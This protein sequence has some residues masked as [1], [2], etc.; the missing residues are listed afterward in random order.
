MRHFPPDVILVV[1]DNVNFIVNKEIKPNLSLPRE[2]R[3]HNDHIT[4]GQAYPAVVTQSNYYNTEVVVVNDLGEKAHHWIGYGVYNEGDK[5]VT[6][7]MPDDILRTRKVA[8]IDAIEE[9]ATAEYLRVFGELKER[10]DQIA[11]GE[12]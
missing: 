11:R 12:I 8:W 7:Q 10:R 9:K 4:V 1:G 2:E 3:D 5:T 6:S